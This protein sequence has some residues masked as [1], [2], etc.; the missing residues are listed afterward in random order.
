MESGCLWTKSI[1]PARP[2]SRGPGSSLCWRL[3]KNARGLGKAT[4]RREQQ[5]CTQNWGKRGRGVKVCMGLLL[6]GDEGG[7]NGTWQI[8]E[9]FLCW[10]A[11]TL[12]QAYPSPVNSAK[13]G[14]WF[15]WCSIPTQWT[16]N[17]VMSKRAK[18]RGTVYNQAPH[19]LQWQKTSNS[20]ENKPSLPRLD[21]GSTIIFFLLLS[22]GYLE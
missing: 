6:R 3:V 9:I 1:P 20:G 7:W 4:W 17:E 21:F 13:W 12:C 19:A 10:L 16:E 15:L 14:R 2:Y 11:H 5:K 18:P 8:K 22:P